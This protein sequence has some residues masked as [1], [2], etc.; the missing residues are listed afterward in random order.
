MNKEGAAIRVIIESSS[1]VVI[2][3][4][5]WLEKQMTNNEAEYEAMIYGLELTLKLGV[6]NLK[7]ILD[8]KL[9][10][11]HVNKVFEAK[12]Q[13]MRV[14]CDKVSRLVKCFR[15]I[16]IQ[17]IKRELNARADKLVKG[18]AYGEYDKKE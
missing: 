16:D 12:D 13:R 8:L 17:V 18:A 9:V 15:R 1:R 6:Q 10:S 3:E 5:F 14:Y 2:E 4:A 11:G 7:V